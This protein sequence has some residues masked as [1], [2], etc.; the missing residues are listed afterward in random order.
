MAKIASLQSKKFLVPYLQQMRKRRLRGVDSPVSRYYLKL[1]GVSSFGEVPTAH[2]GGGGVIEFYFTAPSS[3]LSDRQY[4]LDGS[5]ANASQIFLHED[6]TVRFNAGAFS[7]VT[8]DGVAV[9]ASV[10]EYPLDGE[11]HMLTV[12]S[13]GSAEVANIGGRGGDGLKSFDGIIYD[14][15]IQGITNTDVYPTG[16]ACW[17]MSDKGS[18]IQA[19]SDNGS[20]MTLYNVDHDTYWYKLVDGEFVQVTT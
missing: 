14:L 18:D 15:K 5:A 8:L 20:D 17:A 12:I 6:G 11:I 13:S 2:V 16:T 9:T 10:T 4:L 19:E 3:S 7:S 1:D